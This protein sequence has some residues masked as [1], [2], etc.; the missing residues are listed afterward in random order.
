MTGTIVADAGQSVGMT[1]DNARPPLLRPEEMPPVH[2]Q[3]A[4][5]QQW[6]AL[7]GQL[8]FS[9]YS[10]WLHLIEADGRPTPMLTQIEEMS[11]LPDLADE[12]LTNLM[13]LCSQLTEELTPGG[14]VAFLLS[15]PGRAPISEWDLAWA[16]AL[17]AASSRHGVPIFP[18]H[19]AN[20][21]TVAVIAP[22][23]LGDLAVPA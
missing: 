7:M 14:R 22:D 19:R 9:G 21:E 3:E 2:T 18:I 20:S 1:N 8:G 13:W 23:E 11:H 15:R 6:R 16:R 12:R 5:H 4:L 10:L 17:T